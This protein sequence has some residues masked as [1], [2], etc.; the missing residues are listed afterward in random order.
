MFDRDNHR[1][2]PDGRE[3]IEESLARGTVLRVPE[4]STEWLRA[5]AA[6]VADLE[7]MK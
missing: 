7:A 6:D 3:V 4:S 2:E 5:D 1:G